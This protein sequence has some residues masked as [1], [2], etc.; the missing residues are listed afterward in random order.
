MARTKEEQYIIS[1]YETVQQLGA[2]LDHPV[3]R[4]A[5]GKKVGLSPKVTDTICNVLT[6]SNFIRKEG[7]VN[8]SLTRNGESLALHI[9]GE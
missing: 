2:D 5:I 4:Y 3:D 7:D 6:K 8:I 1:I 9:L